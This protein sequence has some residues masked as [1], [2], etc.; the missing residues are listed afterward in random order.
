MEA[1]Q[2]ID[3]G[4]G[5]VKFTMV[6]LPPQGRKKAKK[7][8]KAPPR[9]IDRK[10]F[11]RA[12][13]KV[14]TGVVDL[15]TMQDQKN[16]FIQ[17]IREKISEEDL[18]AATMS[19][20]SVVDNTQRAYASI[21]KH[22]FHFNEAR[23][24]EKFDTSV[25][26]I[27]NWLVH[28]KYTESSYYFVKV[29]RAA[30]TFKTEVMEEENPFDSKRLNRQWMGLVK[31]AAK[32]KKI[33]K[34]A[35]PLDRRWITEIYR[36]YVAFCKN[37][38]DVPLDKYRNIIIVVIQYYTLARV[39]DI[40]WLRACDISLQTME[41]G[42][43]KLVIFFPL[44]KND[45]FANGNS[46]YILED[47]RQSFCPVK[48]IVLYMERARLTMGTTSEYIDYNFLIRCVRR[49]KVDGQNTQVHGE[50]GIASSLYVQQTK[51]MLRAVGY[52]APFTAISAKAGGVSFSFE[53]GA[54]KAQLQHHGRWKSEETA[55]LYQRSWSRYKESAAETFKSTAVQR[56]AAEWSGGIQIAPVH[57][58]QGLQDLPDIILDRHDQPLDMVEYI[59]E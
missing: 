43:K 45:Q 27:R 49:R 59:T 5:T 56:Y 19:A 21:I 22:L 14:N 48:L 47:R 16:P 29:V 31:R 20:E 26:A 13:V 50:R 18:E 37:L 8:Q 2:L 39:S 41:N 32:T 53:H 52:A 3:T 34:K 51:K 42:E 4:S 33:T 46:S 58:I 23:G 35:V 12:N 24:V 44:A 6:E 7:G 36:K 9:T 1:Y 28:M 30:V 40:F 10:Q 55:A 25:T 57:E 54:T 38:D 17:L 11:T 15:P